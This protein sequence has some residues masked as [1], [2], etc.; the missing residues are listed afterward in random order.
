MLYLDDVPHVEIGAEVAAP[1]DPIG[2]VVPSELP[3]G[4]VATATHRGPF[5]QVGSA[6]DAVIAWCDGR[7]LERTGVRWEVYGHWDDAAP[8]P[9]VDVFWQLR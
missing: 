6:H 8:D 7:G 2:R 1:F 3:A 5:E 4:R 9:R